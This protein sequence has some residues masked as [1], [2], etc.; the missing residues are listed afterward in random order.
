MTSSLP[1]QKMLW[2][3]GFCA[4]LIIT[5]D[6]SHL[7]TPNQIIIKFTIHTNQANFFIL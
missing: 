6:T 2:E 7:T 3:S 5:F 4:N 1:L